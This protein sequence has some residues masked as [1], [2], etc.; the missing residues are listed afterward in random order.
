[1]ATG[2]QTLPYHVWLPESGSSF[3]YAATFVIEIYV[4]L[5]L[6]FLVCGIDSFFI[7]LCGSMGIQ[8][9]LLAHRMRNLKSDSK[10]EIIRETLKE[11]ILHQKHLIV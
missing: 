10:E 6:L 11:C 5:V 2:L 4:I 3:Y 7:A 8:F 1:M 9:K